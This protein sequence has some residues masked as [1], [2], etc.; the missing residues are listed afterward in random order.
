MVAL[1]IEQIAWDVWGLSHEVTDV[2]GQ[3][4]V[5]DGPNQVRRRGPADKAENRLP[6]NRSVT[7]QNYK[8]R[9]RRVRSTHITHSCQAGNY[10]HVTKLSADR[11][12]TGYRH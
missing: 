2:A 7:G 3:A 8:V 6:H 12:T 5:D 4:V 1:K 9:R 11:I 10:P